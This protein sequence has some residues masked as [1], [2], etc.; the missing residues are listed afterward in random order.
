[1]FG[2]L[3]CVC[4]VLCV[5]EFSV[6]SEA[7]YFGCVGGWEWCVVYVEVYRV[8]VLCWVGREKC[9]GCFGGVE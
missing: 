2:F 7:E 8:V 9:G 4:D 3:C 6:K 1:M 5:S